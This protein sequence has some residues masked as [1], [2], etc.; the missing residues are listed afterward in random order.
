MA[1]RKKSNKP[2]M[3]VLVTLAVIGAWTV[4]DNSTRFVKSVAYTVTHFE[5]KA[6]HV[7]LK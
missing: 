4:V 6:P 7:A 5:I 2:L 3:I 1:Q